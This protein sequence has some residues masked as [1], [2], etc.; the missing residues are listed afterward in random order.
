MLW[1]K[2]TVALYCCVVPQQCSLTRYS[3]VLDSVRSAPSGARASK[4]SAARRAGRSPTHRKET[5]RRR[6]VRRRSPEEGSRQWGVLCPSG[7]VLCPPIACSAV[8]SES[9]P[10]AWCIVH[11]VLLRWQDAGV[12]HVVCCMLYAVRCMS[13][14]ACCR[15]V[16]CCMMHDACCKCVGCCTLQ[17][18]V[19]AL[20]V[21]GSD[22]Q[23]YRKRE[24][25]GG[26]VLRCHGGRVPLTAEISAR[27][28][29]RR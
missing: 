2:Y 28:D 12:L 1:A 3:A 19:D 6:A 26:V 27:W 15:C 13:H 14:G 22:L 29:E 9:V 21:F 17:F 10:L 8:A 25:L 5:G 4:P 24:H 7:G 20:Q 16:G 18:T 23:L 11:G